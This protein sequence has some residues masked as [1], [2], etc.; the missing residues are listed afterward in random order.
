MCNHTNR[1]ERIHENSQRRERSKKGV[2][3]PVSGHRGLP[4][5]LIVVFVFLPRIDVF[6]PTWRLQKSR[7]VKNVRWWPMAIAGSGHQRDGWDSWPAAICAQDL[8]LPST[9]PAIVAI[10]EQV[11]ERAGIELSQVDDGV[12]S[13]WVPHLAETV[14]NCALNTQRECRPLDL[15]LPWEWWLVAWLVLLLFQI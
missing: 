4:I 1:E 5:P 12:L 15:S 9:N 10:G 13:R 2:S 11:E 7:C 3:T 8:G 6:E 14:S